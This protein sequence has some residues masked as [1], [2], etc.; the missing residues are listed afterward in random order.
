MTI[1]RVI[2]R[3]FKGLKETELTFSKGINILVGDNE[4]G[5]STVLEA[6]N[7]ALTKQLN[8]R[9]AGYDLHPFLFHQSIVQEFVQ[10]IKGGTVMPPLMI[11]IEVYLTDDPALAQHKGTNNSR[12]AD[13]PG[14]RLRI[15]LDENF[16]E[17]YRAYIEDTERIETV[18]GG[19][20]P[21][22]LEELRRRGVDIQIQTPATCTDR[23]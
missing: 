22:R 4:T 13:C 7:L 3:N 21:H 19:V 18:S 2:I 20:L 12:N 14:V 9:D 11:D 10:S 1:E 17:E 23:S 16:R 15:E 8:R 5:K 6:I